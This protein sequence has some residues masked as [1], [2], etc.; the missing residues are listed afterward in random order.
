MASKTKQLK[1]R[2]ALKLKKQGRERKKRMG[3]AST[4]SFP[5][6][7]PERHADLNRGQGK[8]ESAVAND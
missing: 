5:I 4:P 1:V 3:K 2:K 8:D 7:V 6:H